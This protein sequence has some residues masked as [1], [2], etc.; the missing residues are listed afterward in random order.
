MG[1]GRTFNLG[2]RVLRVP[3]FLY[4]VTCD[5]LVVFTVNSEEMSTQWSQNALKKDYEL[6]P[7]LKKKLVLHAESGVNLPYLVLHGKNKMHHYN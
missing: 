4:N 5:S 1:S 6:S 7:F 3:N 2:C